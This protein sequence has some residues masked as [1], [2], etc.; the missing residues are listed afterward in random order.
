[1][2][3][4][5]S[6]LEYWF[7]RHAD[8]AVVA[9]QQR[10]LWWSKNEETDRAIAERF[11]SCT[12]AAACGKLDDWAV[13][14][15]G[16]LALILLTDQFP[17]NMYRDQPR[18]FGFD[19]FA[20]RW[21]RV[22]LAQGRSSGYSFIF[23]WNTPNR[24]KIRTARCSCSTSCCRSCRFNTRKPSTDFMI[25]RSGI[26]TSLPGSAASRIATRYSGA[27]RPK[28]KYSFCARPGRRFKKYVIVPRRRDDDITDQ[29][30]SLQHPIE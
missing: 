29:L 22:G 15:R 24:S 27:Y 3:N 23:R 5:D 14:P 7:G 11:E 16:T 19:S 13:S 1:M 28:R 26:A 4:V 2:E 6:I 9:E 20:H 17:R 25:L 8:D 10:G 18:A 30:F 21:C 12:A